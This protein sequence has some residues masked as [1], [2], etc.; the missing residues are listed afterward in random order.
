MTVHFG[1]RLI[2]IPSLRK[3][4]QPR[5]GFYVS[6]KYSFIGN[7]NYGFIGNINLDFTGNNIYP[8]CGNRNTL[9][10]GIIGSGY[11][12]K[13]LESKITSIASLLCQPNG[14]YNA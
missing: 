2:C 12:P 6:N 11:M 13:G 4:A 5:A 10:P 3:A 7:I 14:G 8:I 1:M 9:V